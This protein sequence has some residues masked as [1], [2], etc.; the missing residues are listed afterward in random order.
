MAR[1]RS[2]TAVLAENRK[3]GF[4]YHSQYSHGGSAAHDPDR[5]RKLL[6]NRNELNKLLGRTVEKGLSDGPCMTRR[7]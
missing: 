1:D 2:P 6:L 5:P 4:D 3:A 7:R